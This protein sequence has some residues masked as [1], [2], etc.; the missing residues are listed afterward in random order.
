MYGLPTKLEVTMRLFLSILVVGL[1]GCATLEKSESADYAK[2][3]KGTLVFAWP[4]LSPEALPYRGGSTKGTPVT[5]VETPS[6]EWQALQADNLSALE[7]DRRAILAMAGDYRVSFQ[8]TETAGFVDGY[9]PSKPYFSWATEH[10]RVIEEEARFISLQHILAMWFQGEDGSVQGPM[11]MKHWR[12]DWS[13]EDRVLCRYVRDG[14]FARHEVRES[15]A[16][17]AWTQAVFQV[18]DSPRYEVLGR[19]KHGNGLAIWH[20]WECRRPLPRREFSVRDD[21]N[22]LEGRHS[23][24]ITPAGWVHEQHNRKLNH[25]DEGK[26]YLAQEIGVNRYERISDPDLGAADESWEKTKHYWQAVRDT[27][28][29]VMADSTRF[30]IAKTVDD[31]KLYARHFAYAAKI[32]GGQVD[33]AA[34]AAHAQETVAKYVTVIK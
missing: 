21:Y 4:F 29:K 22:V 30:R 1:T 16:K 18:D 32:E 24:T 34:A 10:I 5:L 17:G 3:S 33:Q 27:W 6:P 8:F 7:R 23:I 25:S 2:E 13:Y 28:A 19:W 15:A 26:H 9:T 20:S 31:Q 12:Q 11:V 14:E